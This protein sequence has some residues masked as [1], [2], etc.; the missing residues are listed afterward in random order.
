M[1]YVFPKAASLDIETDT[2]ILERQAS[3]GIRGM[4]PH[5][6][7]I[8]GALDSVSSFSPHCTDESVGSDRRP[9][10]GNKICQ[11]EERRKLRSN[12]Q[13]QNK[14][15]EPV[16]VWNLVCSFYGA[17][18]NRSAVRLFGHGAFFVSTAKT[19]IHLSERDLI[20]ENGDIRCHINDMFDMSKSLGLLT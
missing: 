10:K 1:C 17:V 9:K 6:Y 12:S 18:I 4:L 11:Q 13:C 19:M 15:G 7:D 2:K 3:R 5:N 16:Y 20:K 8:G 14:M